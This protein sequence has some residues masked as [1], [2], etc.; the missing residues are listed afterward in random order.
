[1]SEIRAIC[2]GHSVVVGH[3]HA[4]AQ[5]MQRLIDEGYRFIMAGS[6]IN[7]NGLEKGLELA[8]RN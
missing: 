4:N 7:Y 6:T 5:N 2:Q 8:N 3:P 1:M